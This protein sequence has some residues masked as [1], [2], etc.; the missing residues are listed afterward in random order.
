VSVRFTVTRRDP[1]SRARTGVIE[2]AHGTFRTPAFMPVATRGAVKT[3]PPKELRD[4]G[5]EIVLSNVYHL[6][7][8]PGIDVVA[9]AGGLHRFMAWDGPLL[10]DSGGYQIFSLAR[11]RKITDDGVDFH[12]PIDG[13]PTFLR[14]EDVVAMQERLGV[15]IAMPLD[16]PVPN[17][18]PREKAEEAMRRTHDWLARS[19]KASAREETALF[20]IAQGSLFPDLR[21]RSVKEILEHDPPGVAVG[22][23][24]MGED[25]DTLHELAAHTA[26]LV[27]EEKPRYLM[28]VGTPQDI[29]KAVR[30]GYD[31][32][33]CVLPTRTARTGWA[34]TSQGVL[35]LR[36]STYARDARPL[37][38]ACACPACRTFSRAYLR[39]CVSIREILGITMLSV[40]NIWFYMRLM[41]RLRASIGEE[42]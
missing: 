16:Q 4:L 30:A 5:V 29:E 17:P 41:E 8:R 34:Y 10:T 7:L 36:N 33:D 1:S 35:K 24:S 42:S 39:H 26:S 13:K 20:G 3:I 31:L 22:G 27:P 38:E 28:G 40:H 14:P 21:E 15:D 32:F 9:E 18:A 6:A 12:S 2:T 11:L 37:D 23:L 25:N 19:M